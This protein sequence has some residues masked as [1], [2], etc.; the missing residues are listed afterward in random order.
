MTGAHGDAIG[1]AALGGGIGGLTAEI[2][3]EAMREEVA[4]RVSDRIAEA[5]GDVDPRQIEAEELSRIAGL[6][7]MAAI[8]L[9]T[10]VNGD[11][12][13]AQ[14]AARN[15]VENNFVF[16]LIP[17]VSAAMKIYDILTTAQGAIEAYESGGLEA[18]IEYGVE[19][20]VVNLLGGKGLKI[21]GKMVD[22][23]KTFLRNNGIKV[24]FSIPGSKNTRELA[25]EGPSAGKG[26]GPISQQGPSS[27]SSERPTTFESSAHGNKSTSQQSSSISSN[28]TTGRSVGKE[29]SLSKED[30]SKT[31]KHD[32][33]GKFYKNKNDKL[34]YTKDQAKHGGSTWKVYKETGKGLE[35]VRDLDKNGKLMEKHKGEI[36]KFIPKGELNG[37]GGK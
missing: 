3:A 35:W 1:R 7:E 17:I 11:I 37:V 5:E 30:I 2:L 8:T 24:E 28:S 20:A 9:T 19:E 32:R 10:L 34:F 25:F 15:A 22:K 4:A 27:G 16:A 12:Q 13:A 26:K 18:L 23:A 29:F 6:A 21:L 14:G 36:G 33:F 31:Y